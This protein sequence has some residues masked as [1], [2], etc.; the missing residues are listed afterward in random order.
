MGDKTQLATISLA[1]QYKNM[2]SVLMGTTLAMVIA[3]AIG[4]GIGVLMH[5]HIPEKTIKWF[6]ASI[7]VLFGLVGVYKVLSLRLNI[8]FSVSIILFI[9]MVTVYCGH[10][11]SGL[12]AK[13]NLRLE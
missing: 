10:R 13:P 11:L 2:F 7:F 8:L 5:K 1:V 4:I 9:F 6:S 3:D 12:R